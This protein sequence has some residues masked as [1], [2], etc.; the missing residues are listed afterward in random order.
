M[1]SLVDTAVWG[2][3]YNCMPMRWMR[4]WSLILCG[5][6]VCLA[7]PAAAASAALDSGGLEMQ[8]TFPAEAAMGTIHVRGRIAAPPE[9]VWRAVA[10]INR[11]ATWMPMVT[12]AYFFSEAA[13]KAIP[14][15]AT[16]NLDFFQTLRRRFPGSAPPPPPTG[17]TTR[18]S[19]EAFDLPWPIS[20]EWVARRYR[21]DASQAA[22]HRYR[23]AWEKIYDP[24]EPGS[25]GYWVLDPYPGDTQATLGTYHF[26]VTA[27]RGLALRL[28]KL[29]VRS[30]VTKLFRAIREQAESGRPAVGG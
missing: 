11:W 2:R 5:W 6:F 28:L 3:Q 12:E 27:R 18:T 17:V 20:N 22:E 26:E 21:F 19:Y 25:K 10:D 1:P 8:I 9:A 15:N 16:K 4:C 13:A 24:N 14:Q 23:V 7:S 30:A 29:G